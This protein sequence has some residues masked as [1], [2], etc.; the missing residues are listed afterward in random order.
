MSAFVVVAASLGLALLVLIV[1]E[2]VTIRR[3]MTAVQRLLAD[4]AAPPDVETLAMVAEE[5]ARVA[6]QDVAAARMGGPPALPAPTTG[7]TT[8]SRSMSPSRIK[9]AGWAAGATETM[10]R[11]REG[12]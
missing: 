4:R 3:R 10:R 6:V 5:A 7:D 12:A 8:A 11:L 2:L 1:I 9:A